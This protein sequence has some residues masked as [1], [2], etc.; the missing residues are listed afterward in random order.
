[1][2][3]KLILLFG[4]LALAIAASSLSLFLFPQSK[5]NTM[6]SSPE[7]NDYSKDWKKVDSLVNAGLPKSA[8]ELVEIIYQKAQKE[9]NHP[10]FVKSTMYK[11]KLKAD[12]Q[13]EFLETTIKD[14]EAVIQKSETPV[15]QILYS[16]EADLYWR[17][18]QS[19][20]YKFMDRT[21][22]MNVDKKD[23][24]TWDLKTL[25][26]SVIDNYIASLGNSEILK[27]T[28]LKDFDAI[29][30]SQKDSKK[31]RP[32][33]YDFLA[34]RAIEFFRNDE[35]SIIQPAF[36]FELD[37]ENYFS[38]ASDFQKVKIDTK[39]SLSLK[40]F[41]LTILQDLLSFHLNDSDPAALIDADLIR[42]DFV[43]DNSTLEIKDSLFLSALLS[44]EKE[45]A[46]H[47]TV[48]D[49]GYKIAE[50]Y[51][52]LGGLYNPNISDQHK[53]DKKKAFDKCKEVIEKYQGSDGAQNCEVLQQQLEQQNIQLTI[54]NVNVPEKPFLAL[55]NF[56][57]TPKLWF[58]II[59]MDYDEAEKL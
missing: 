35:S 13:E 31:Y 57:N 37:K 23:I 8:L 7:Y 28:N 52:R 39:D 15:K 29:V 18:Y 42:F 48:S 6:M 54:E 5:P 1:M 51:A 11:I 44:L 45:Y 3:T 10:Q 22:A 26:D 47:P 59:R 32:T 20:R 21:T 30:V 41:A 56:T 19:N 14:I 12:F 4:L 34:H 43:R 58:R 27:K 38:K 24:R 50:E 25:L 17:Y 16:I 46:S 49:A 53:W 40:Y 36:K 55:L 2:K 9:A 33:L